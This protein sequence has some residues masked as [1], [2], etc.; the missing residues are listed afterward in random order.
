VGVPD[1]ARLILDL[2]RG[3]VRASVQRSFV[4]FT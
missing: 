4:F 2:P 3:A 1:L